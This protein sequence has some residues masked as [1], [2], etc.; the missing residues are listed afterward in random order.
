LARER[1]EFFERQAATEQDK[2]KGEQ[3]S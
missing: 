1:L 3:S 2:N